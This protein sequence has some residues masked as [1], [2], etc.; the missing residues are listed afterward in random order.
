MQVWNQFLHK[1]P[2]MKIHIC[3]AFFNHWYKS[4]MSA[5]KI[6]LHKIRRKYSHFKEYSKYSN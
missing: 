3:S 1:V 4:L 2:P 5:Y 6:I